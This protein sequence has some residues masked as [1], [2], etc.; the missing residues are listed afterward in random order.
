APCVVNRDKLVNLVT[1]QALETFQVNG[2]S[3][4][5]NSVYGVLNWLSALKPACIAIQDNQQKFLRRAYCSVEL[6]MLALHHIVSGCID[7]DAPFVSITPEFRQKV[8]QICLLVPE[9][10]SEMMD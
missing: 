6:F 1:A 2:I 9:A 8:C 3:F 4:S 7:T 10:F 5:A